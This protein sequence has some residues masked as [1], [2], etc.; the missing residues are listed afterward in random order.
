MSG[1]D[2]S[3]AGALG[4]DYARAGFGQ[5]LGFGRRPVVL[6]VD[7][8]NAYFDRASPLY[9]G[10]DDAL[11]ATTTLL[12]AARGAGV[13]VVFTKVLYTDGG[14]D[15][16]LF[17]QKVRG[18]SLFVGETEAGEVAGALQRRDS[19][20]VLTKQFASAF[21]DTPLTALLRDHGIDT[22]LL[23]GLSTSGCVRAS[24]VDAIQL[25]FAPVVVRDAV[26][27]RDPG[28]HEASLF[29]LDAKYADVVDLDAALTYLTSSAVQPTVLPA[30]GT[31]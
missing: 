11:A 28:P 6:V 12:R 8:V 31:A 29:D 3:G 2:D 14:R 25:G 9:A 10:V 13:P 7:M 22:V 16:G 24:A 15:G 21:F 19:E 17:F 1:P 5:R 20:L 27:D 4:Q 23:A 30:T 18:L 26:G